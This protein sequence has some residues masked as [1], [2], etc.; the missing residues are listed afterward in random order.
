MS[1]DLVSTVSTDVDTSADMSVHGGVLT[2]GQWTPA[3]RP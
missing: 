1:P 3:D 2:P